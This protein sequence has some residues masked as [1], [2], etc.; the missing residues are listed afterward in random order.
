M[1][2]D[3]RD[4]ISFVQNRHS[5]LIPRRLFLTGGL[6][7]FALI[8]SANAAPPAVIA[9]GTTIGRGTML[10]VE[11]NAAGRIVAFDSS[12]YLEGNPTGGGDVVVIGSYCGT[13]VLAPIFTRGVKAVIATDA[14]IGL[15]EAGIS[16]LKHGETIG[17][18]VASIAAMSAETSNGR[19]TLLGEISRANAQARALGVTPGMVAYEAAA[20]LAKAPPGKS[21]PTSLGVEEAPVVVEETPKGRIWATPGTT[22]IKEKI[23][24]DVICSGANSSRVMS[25]GV[26]R[27]GAKGAI[28]NDAGI[29]KHNGAV[30]GIQILGERGVA[31]A[32]VSTMSARLAEGQST[33]NTG[34]I[35]VVNP[36][37]AQRGVKVGMSAKEAA[38]LMLA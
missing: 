22:A 7:S 9:D 36:V 13:R 15:D 14:G 4:T 17:V 2:K 18:P 3:R 28:A 11:E 21:I 26:L 25:D 35:S 20:R 8:R 6:A 37:A 10:V 16:G 33:W 29:S 27:M 31:A 34:I 1:P 23:P 30:E 19:S 12:T 32:S 38:R 5:V 24:N